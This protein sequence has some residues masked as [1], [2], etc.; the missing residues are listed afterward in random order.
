MIWH[1]SIRDPKIFPFQAKVQNVR[2]VPRQPIPNVAETIER[3][4]AALKP[5]V[6][7]FQYERTAKQAQTFLAQSANKLNILLEGEFFCFL[8]LH[9]NRDGVAFM[10][11]YL[12]VI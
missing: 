7:D 8:I 11:W 3:Y 4:L 5:L 1:I 12:C 10:V 9:L 6:P 2:Q